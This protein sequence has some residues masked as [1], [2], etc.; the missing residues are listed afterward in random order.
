MDEMQLT[1]PDIPQ[2]TGVRFQ[3]PGISITQ[4]FIWYNR[5]FHRDFIVEILQRL[6]L[7]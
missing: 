6:P 5:G 2:L 3:I 4:D 7:V 1:C